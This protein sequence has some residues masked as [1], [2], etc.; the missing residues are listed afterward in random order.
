MALP[1]ANLGL[2]SVD[3]DFPGHALLIGDCLL[4]S[5]AEGAVVQGS[6][7]DVDVA[8]PFP[9][10]E[11]PIG[12]RSTWEGC[13]GRKAVDSGGHRAEVVPPPRPRSAQ[14]RQG[15]LQPSPNL[16]ITPWARGWLVGA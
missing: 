10:E 16:S 15:L 6:G 7:H 2:V 3:E 4:E 13:L 1:L 5:M 9:A 11:D 12:R 8:V 14:P